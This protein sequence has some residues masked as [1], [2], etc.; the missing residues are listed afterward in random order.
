MSAGTRLQARE[1]VPVA[2]RF[3]DLIQPYCDRL[4]VAGSLRRR[5]PTVGDVELCVIPRVE[6]VQ[7][8]TTDL[9][10]ESVQTAQVDRLHEF[11]DRAL[12]DGIVSKRPRADGATFWGP[13][14]KYLTF[15]GLPFDVFSAV[16]DWRKPGTVPTAE[17]DRFGI[18]LVIRTGPS[19]YSHRLVTPK[20]QQ[21]EV[22]KKGNGQPILKPGL[23]PVIYRV[24]DGWLTYRTSAERIPTPTEE[25]VYELLG[26]EYAEPWQRG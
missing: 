10:G 2:R 22:G 21:A 11:L 4:V 20:D 25:S 17:P 3:V 14:A 7:T 1:V 15:E 18:M 19:G 24:Q 8:T 9:F 13:R 12:L 23:L 5:L 6:A 26:L 16:N